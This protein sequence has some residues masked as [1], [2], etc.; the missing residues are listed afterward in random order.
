[1]Q[2]HDGKLDEVIQFFTLYHAFNNIIDSLLLAEVND[3][4]RFFAAFY[5][6]FSL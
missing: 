3:R 6:Q 2:F 4:F 5:D 1:M